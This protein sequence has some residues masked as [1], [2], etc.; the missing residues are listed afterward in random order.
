M[1]TINYYWEVGEGDGAGE[2]EGGISVNASFPFFMN[3]AQA[4]KKGSG[5]CVCIASTWLVAFASCSWIIANGTVVCEEWII[6]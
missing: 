5:D 4:R 6:Y 3:W 2:G 1:T